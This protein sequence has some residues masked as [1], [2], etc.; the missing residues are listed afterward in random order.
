MEVLPFPLRPGWLTAPGSRRARSHGEPAA[1]NARR[2]LGNKSASPSQCP[3]GPGSA[4]LARPHSQFPDSK[5]ARP[6]DGLNLGNW[7]RGGSRDLC[8][9]SSPS[10][11]HQLRIPTDQRVPRAQAA[12]HQRFQL[13]GVYEIELFHEVVK[14]LVA[15]VDVGFRPHLG[16]PVKM[17]DV[18]VDKDPEQPG[19]DL[20]HHREEVLGEGSTW[21]ERH[22]HE[23][24]SAKSKPV[25]R[26]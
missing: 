17:V 7:F 16:D 6:T 25:P 12:T 10:P 4:A 1:G 2:P 14:V 8:D 3:T 15:G 5:T 9:P 18:D 21:E 24:P 23:K 13:L 26:G 20:L 11:P 22:N 19:Q